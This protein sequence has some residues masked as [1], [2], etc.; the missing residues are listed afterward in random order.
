MGGNMSLRKRENYNRKERMR[1]IN[2]VR[3]LE[4]EEKRQV[5]LI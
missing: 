5:K 1:D 4:Q 3:F 2:R